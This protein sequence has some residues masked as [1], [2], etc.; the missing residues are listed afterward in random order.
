[1]IK[2]KFENPTSHSFSVKFPGVALAI[3]PK[4]VGDNAVIKELPELPSVEKWLDNLAARHRAI[5][6]TILDSENEEVIEVTASTSDQENVSDDDGPE[7]TESE[8]DTNTETSV[9][10]DTFKTMIQSVEK[11]GGGWWKVSVSGLEEAISVRG[12]E[13]ENEAIEKAYDEYLEE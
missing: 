6:V 1:M 12:C 3:P 10:L 5:K 11:G 8:T 13:D 4:I 9:T 7:T 2:V